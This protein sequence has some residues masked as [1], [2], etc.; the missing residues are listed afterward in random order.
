MIENLVI[1]KTEKKEE[2]K[3]IKEEKVVVGEYF[4]FREDKRE[5]YSGLKIYKG[6]TN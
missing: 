3:K 5:V 1:E 6:I 4:R 2:N